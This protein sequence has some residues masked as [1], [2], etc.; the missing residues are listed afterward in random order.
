MPS[1][2]EDLMNAVGQ[3]EDMVENGQ[4]VSELSVEELLTGQ[5]ANSEEE[6]TT[7]EEPAE[8]TEETKQEEPANDEAATEEAQ[9]AESPD[10]SALQARIAELESQNNSMKGRFDKELKPVQMLQNRFGDLNQYAPFLEQMQ[11]DPQFR[12]HM[13]QYFNRGAA[14]A[15]EQSLDDL[16]TSDPKQVAKFINQQVNN[17]LLEQQQFAQ[18][19]AQKKMQEQTFN[20]FASGLNSSRQQFVEAAKVD[21]Q[22]ANDMQANFWNDFY[23]GDVFKYI[24]AFYNR[25]AEIAKAREEGRK[26]GI[27]EV[28]KQVAD[29]KNGAKRTAEVRGGQ[30]K[31]KAQ[32]VDTE[33]VDSIIREIVKLNPMSEEWKRLADQYESLTGRSVFDTGR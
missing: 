19:Q 7:P 15:S 32:S 1:S 21:E 10:V 18:Q 8:T 22:V 17:A 31:Q 12:A 24:G 20:A 16:D 28:T 13:L 9:P 6:E 30:Q 23:K 26:A 5:A 25:D 33:D 4:D 2:T 29:A 11:A 14:T 27:S 3:L